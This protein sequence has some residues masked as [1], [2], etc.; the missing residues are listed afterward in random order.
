MQKWAKF[1]TFYF[2]FQ[3]CQ[4]FVQ[5]LTNMKSNKSTLITGLSKI[6]LQEKGKGSLLCCNTNITN[7]CSNKYYMFKQLF[8]SLLS[9][10]I[11]LFIFQLHSIQYLMPAEILTHY[12]FGFESQTIDSGWLLAMMTRVK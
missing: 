7:N 2:S 1:Q 5:L 11:P 6:R 12:N 4:L 3:S 10:L 8:N 9:I